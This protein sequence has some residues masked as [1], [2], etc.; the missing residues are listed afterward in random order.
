MEEHKGKV[1][2]S[3]PIPEPADYYAR[4]HVTFDQVHDKSLRLA[5]WLREN[6]VRQGGR[7]VVGGANSTGWVVAFTAIHLLGAVPVFLNSTL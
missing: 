7:V 4:E 1:M 2:L 5:A 3:S 6:G